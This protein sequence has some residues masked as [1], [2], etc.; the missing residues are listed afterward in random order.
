METEECIKDDLKNDF[1]EE[2]ITFSV[3]GISRTK[4][5]H[6]AGME[7]IEV[8]PEIYSLPQVYVV[9]VRYSDGGTCGTTYGHWAIAGVRGDAEEATFFAK[10]VREGTSGHHRVWDGYFAAWEDIEIYE[11]KVE[12]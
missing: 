11:L 2:R 3:T 9:I 1:R 5:S 10:S 4:T 6:G 7:P 8:P 12:V